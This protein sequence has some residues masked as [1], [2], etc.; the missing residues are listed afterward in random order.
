MV[1]AQM[2]AVITS[3]DRWKGTGGR[4]GWMGLSSPEVTAKDKGQINCFPWAPKS[5]VSKPC[6]FLFCPSLTTHVVS[7]IHSF[8]HSSFTC[9][10]THSFLHIHPSIHSSIPLSMDA[11]ILFFKQTFW[12]CIT[13][14]LLCVK[15]HG[16]MKLKMF[17]P[18][19]RDKSSYRVK[20]SLL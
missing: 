13:Y 8:I 15:G 3:G 19:R 14:S 7:P 2:S 20:A 12:A 18:R 6:I 4:G 9:W 17:L 10:F 1:C 11:V 16:K 5:L